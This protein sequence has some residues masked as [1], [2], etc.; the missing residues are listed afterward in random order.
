MEG[1]EPICE[2]GAVRGGY[3]LLCRR[4]L[5]DG[6]GRGAGRI[7]GVRATYLRMWHTIGCIVVVLVPDYGEVGHVQVK[8]RPLE[9]VMT[10]RNKTA[11]NLLRTHF[12]TSARPRAPPQAH[13]P[14][15]HTKP[16]RM[17]TFKSQYSFGECSVSYRAESR[18]TH[19]CCLLLL[20]YSL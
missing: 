10:S 2:D 12:R 20:R 9:S 4:R 17:P 19:G 8:L 11:K 1:N 7:Y 18:N 13:T 15:R 14:R 5:D 16:R 6:H 3:E